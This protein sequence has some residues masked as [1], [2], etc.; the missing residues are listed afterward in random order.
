MSQPQD[1]KVLQGSNTSAFDAEQFIQNLEPGELI[2]RLRKSQNLTQEK[3][4]RKLKV[5]RQ[6]ISKWER[7]EAHPEEEH[8]LALAEALH[9][10]V[11]QIDEDYA[12]RQEELKALEALCNYDTVRNLHH[13]NETLDQLDSQDHC[14]HKADD[15]NLSMLSMLHPS[16]PKDLH[17]FIPGLSGMSPH[18]PSEFNTPGAKKTQKSQVADSD[19]YKND[20]SYDELYKTSAHKSALRKLADKIKALLSWP[21]A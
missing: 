14:I 15:P 9:V 2:A 21:K 10:P 8:L 19:W 17:R 12:R 5:S 1:D 7:G 20:C 18:L 16:L 13:Q 4:A 11:E 6:A 3:L